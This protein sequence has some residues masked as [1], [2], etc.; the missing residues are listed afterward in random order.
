MATTKNFAVGPLAWTHIASGR[1]DG[2]IVRVESSQSFHFAVTVGSRMIP[3]ELPLQS[4]HASAGLA[5]LPLVAMQQLW[6]CAPASGV[7]VVT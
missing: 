7:L 5:D 3:P 1:A 2:A 6:A 4:G